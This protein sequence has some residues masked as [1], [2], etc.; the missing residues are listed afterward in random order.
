MSKPLRKPVSRPVEVSNDD[1]EVDNPDVEDEESGGVT[2]KP[3][4]MPDN[5]EY[6]YVYY[7]EAGNV[8]DKSAN[9]GATTIPIENKLQVKLLWLNNITVLI[10]GLRLKGMDW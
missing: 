9:V 7:D 4:K 6:Y 10:L 2:S 8:L 5:Y 1:V 3:S